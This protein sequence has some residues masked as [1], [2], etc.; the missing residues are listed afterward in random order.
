MRYLY[1]FFLF[2]YC[3][4]FAQ[5]AESD[6][7]FSPKIIFRWNIPAQIGVEIPLGKKSSFYPKIGYIVKAYPYS[8]PISNNSYGPPEEGYQFAG[9]IHNYYYF[10]HGAEAEAEYRYYY[11]MPKRVK[12]HKNTANFA[13]NYFSFSLES[14][15]YS[16]SYSSEF[17]YSFG[18][19]GAVKYGIQRNIDKNGFIGIA[20]GM[21]YY[22]YNL[23]D[24]YLKGDFSPTLS[25]FIGL[26]K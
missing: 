22:H 16:N 24:T 7:T 14:G 11:N 8:Y 12:K 25:T 15:Y 6:S 20:F 9:R 19:G 2:N 23:N 21:G 13:A 26:S 4:I 3:V 10:F 5:K 17:H 1:L 18:I